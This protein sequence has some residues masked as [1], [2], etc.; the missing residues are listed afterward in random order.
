MWLG[1]HKPNVYFRFE[2]FAPSI[3]L[4]ETFG[5][6][7][8]GVFAVDR[9][10][11]AVSELEIKWAGGPAANRWFVQ[12]TGLN[13]ACCRSQ[14]CEWAFK[15]IIYKLSL[16]LVALSHSTANVNDGPG[17]EHIYTQWSKEKA[18]IF[19]HSCFM[20]LLCKWISIFRAFALLVLLKLFLL[21]VQDDWTLTGNIYFLL[22]L[23]SLLIYSSLFLS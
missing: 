8:P 14:M 22:I 19:L 10:R 21:F 18:L 23:C 20:K 17:R 2:C 5:C 3:L 13:L 12:V 15:M 7:C 11:P 16:P 6:I 1:W 9:G 4:T